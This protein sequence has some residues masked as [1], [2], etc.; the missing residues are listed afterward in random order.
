MKGKKDNE[1]FILSIIH[2]PGL[3]VASEKDPCS[4]KLSKEEK[5]KLIDVA[6][7]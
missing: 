4:E 6:N 7:P 3:Q 5:N 2:W 1:L